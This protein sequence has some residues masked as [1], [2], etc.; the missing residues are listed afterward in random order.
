[1][2]GT[3]AKCPRA[4]CD[5]R[6]FARIIGTSNEILYIAILMKTVRCL[7]AALLL[8]VF[9]GG[10]AL[11][12]IEGGDTMHPVIEASA[13]QPIPGGCDDCGGD[14]AMTTMVCSVLGTCMQAVDSVAASW[15]PRPDSVVYTA[16][17]QRITGFEGS[18]EPFPPKTH[19]LT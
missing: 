9:G 17:V 1:M 11:A 6:S 5:D 19:I 3:A 10:M 12:K 8:L 7:L 4:T 16:V 14:K 2:S 15:L 18:P 13:D